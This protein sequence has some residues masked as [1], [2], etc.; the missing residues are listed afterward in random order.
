MFSLFSSKSCQVGICTP[1]VWCYACPPREEMDTIVMAANTISSLRNTYTTYLTAL[2]YSSCR[3]SI[4]HSSFIYY[5]KIS[6]RNKSRKLKIEVHLV[7][8]QLS[9]WFWLEIR[10]RI[11]KAW[12]RCNCL[13]LWV[14]GKGG[15]SA[16][17]SISELWKIGMTRR[18][19][20][21]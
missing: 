19:S 13:Q 4:L 2:F 16:S 10:D 14:G 9:R 17:L 21:L 7:K 12:E 15:I 6:Y 1:C 11:R 20:L 3:P 5:P 18:F 8:G